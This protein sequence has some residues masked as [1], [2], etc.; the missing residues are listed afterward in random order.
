MDGLYFYYA[1]VL[2]A[3]L[4]PAR[5]YEHKILSLE[6]LPIPPLQQMGV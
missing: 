4:E 6:C 2:E 3:G 5:S 1:L